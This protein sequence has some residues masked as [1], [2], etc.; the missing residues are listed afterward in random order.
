M[1]GGGV[2]KRIKQ[3]CSC[4]AYLVLRDLFPQW[5][6]DAGMLSERSIIASY[7]RYFEAYSYKQ[8]KKIGLMSE[9]NLEIFKQR[10]LQ[11]PCEV[12]RNW[13]STQTVVGNHENYVSIRERL[14]LKNKVIYF[15]GGNI[16]HAQDMA[17]LMRL[18]KRMQ[19]YPDAHFLFIGQGDEVE[20]INTL[21]VQWKLTNYS[22]L[23]S[24][25][26][27]EFKLI[28]TDVD[29]GLFSL[30][31]RHTAHNFPGKLLGYM[32]EALP[33]LGSVNYGNDLQC[34]VNGNN[35]GYIHVN[36]E[37]DN[38]FSSAEMLYANEMLRR[39]IGSNAKKL[40]V[41]Q[42]SVSSAACQI[43]KVLEE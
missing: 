10:H 19:C 4:S 15:Y 26:Q 40:L 36:G 9:K 31:A 8:A 25:G 30:S 21:A 17:N 7:F 14:N 28:L 12:L 24:V 5:V 20:L 43:T 41:E 27:S 6:I 37:D 29:V 13:A 22:Y 35:A 18:A 2:V 1:G 38:L 39:E 23:P 42:F 16:G 34:I 3:R 11:Y 32:V 33:I